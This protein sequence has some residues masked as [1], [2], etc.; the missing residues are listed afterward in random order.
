M[1]RRIAI[2]SVFHFVKRH[3]GQVCL[4]LFYI[5]GTSYIVTQ[6]WGLQALGL[7]IRRWVVDGLASSFAMGV[8]TALLYLSDSSSV[9]TLIHKRTLLA[10]LLFATPVIAP[11]TIFS[12]E[13]LVLM[14]HMQTCIY[15][16]EEYRRMHGQYPESMPCE[17]SFG[18]AEYGIGPQGIGYNFYQE[19]YLW[20]G[21]SIVY[22][23]QTGW[24]TTD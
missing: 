22:D 23:S 13:E 20:P 21:V 19:R 16:V 2:S 1:Q 14:R 8:L 18:S 3:F 6:F 4:A 9:R 7:G 5:A 11:L 10:F 24:D 12:I 17:F 15:A